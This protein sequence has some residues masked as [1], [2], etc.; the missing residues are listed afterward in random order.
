MTRHVTAIHSMALGAVT[1]VQLGAWICVGSCWHQ[2]MPMRW[3]C[4]T[5][6]TLH[7]ELC[8]LTVQELVDKKLELA[9]LHEEMLKINHRQAASRPS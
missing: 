4:K 3:C 2:R 1:T 5:Q 6:A 7:A 9:E 8:C